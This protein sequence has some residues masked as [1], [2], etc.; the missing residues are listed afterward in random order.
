MAHA[1][2]SRLNSVLSN[3]PEQRALAQR[4]HWPGGIFA[5]RINDVRAFVIHETSGWPT[6]RHGENMFDRHFFGGA[7]HAP[8]TGETTQL[9]IAG[10]GTVLLGMTLPLQTFHANF[11]NP[12]SLGSETGHAWGNYSGNLHLGPFSQSDN[13]TTPAGVPVRPPYGEFRALH[14]MPGNGWLPLSANAAGVDIDDYPGVRLWHRRLAGEVIV[15]LWTTQRYSGPWR[16]PQRVAE[17]LFNEAQYRAWAL[18]LRYAAERFLIPR[19]FPVLPHKMRSSGFGTAG[20]HGMLRDAMSFRSIVRG[21]E[22]LFR[23]LA[24]FGMTE[25]QLNDDAQVANIYRGGVVL[26]GVAR[27]QLWTRMFDMFRGFHGHG[28]SGDPNGGHDH[29]CPGPMFDFHRLA[30][31][32]WDWWWHPFDFD[33]ARATTNV[34]RRRHSHNWGGDP[35]LQNWD[36][37]TLLTEH[38]FDTP[39]AVYQGRSVAGIHGNT[40]S[41]RTYRLEPNSPVYALAN[42]TLVAARFPPETGN[43]SLAFTLVRHEVFHQPDALAALPDLVRQGLDLPPALPDRI[44]YDAEPSTVYTLYM[45]LGRR[46]GMSFDNITANNPDWLNRLLMRK[47]ECDNG[48]NVHTANPPLPAQVADWNS[49]PPGAGTGGVRRPTILE[50]WQADAPQLR[51]CLDDLRAGNLML[52]PLVDLAWVTPIRILLGDFLGNA[53]V[54]SRTQAA[55]TH[56]I[57]VEVFSKN[58]ISPDFDFNVSANRWDPP[59]LPLQPKPG[60]H[61]LLYQSEW[62]DSPTGNEAAGLQANGVDVSLLGWMTF[63][64]G[65]T[66][67]ARLYPDDGRLPRGGGEVHYD[68]DSFMEWLNNR[69]WKSE[70]RKYRLTD[71][72]G[73]PLAAPAQPR[74][75]TG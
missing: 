37:N 49:V 6:R 34:P 41:P 18:L 20:D 3:A 22:V 21:D 23:S 36:G 29:D 16:Q 26:A 38:F 63:V 55:T 30:R 11:V 2:F 24:T 62:W 5:S 45:H 46:A 19:N 10:D 58:V 59:N 60:G 14:A 39:R 74:P 9:Y 32:V 51:R 56:G 75:R 71:P 31:E 68:P 17:M 72:A 35:Q 67:L 48:I 65:V 57:R 54:I 53:G 4:A 64:E 61:A 1:L 43:V 66:T 13:T 7:G 70:W 15:T 33:A 8:H 50:G 52:A 44:S 73:A 69:T 25:A 28:C 27:N 47:I 12:W 42:G 40:G